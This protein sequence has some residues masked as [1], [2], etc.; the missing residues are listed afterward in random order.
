ML[1]TQKVMNKKLMNW[2]WNHPLTVTAIISMPTF[3][4]VIL[5]LLHTHII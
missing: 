3:V 2:V 1:T 4:T 5:I